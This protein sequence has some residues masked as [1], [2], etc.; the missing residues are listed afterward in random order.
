MEGNYIAELAEKL[1]LRFVLLGN[2]PFV[3]ENLRY[4]FTY[5]TSTMTLAA[6]SHWDL[7]TRKSKYSS[8]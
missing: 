4:K 6:L 1:K 5:F 7:L 8:L 2:I 3:I